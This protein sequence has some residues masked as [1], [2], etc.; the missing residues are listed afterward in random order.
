MPQYTYAQLKAAVNGR[1]HSKIGLL[2]DPRVS[3]NNGARELYSIVDLRSSKR[4]A[5]LAP[6]LFQDVYSYTWPTDGK[7]MAFID[8]QRQTT[9]RPKLERWSLVGEANFDQRKTLSEGLIAFT[10]RD[11]ARKLLVSTQID[12]RTLTVSPLDSTT[13]GGGTWT[14]VGDA[15]NIRT[16]SQNYVK[17]N[18]SLEF[19]MNAGGT[20]AGVQ[21]TALTTFDLTNYLANGSVFVWA[22]ITTTTYI[23]S[24]TLRLGSSSSNFYYQTVTATNEGTAFQQGWNLLRFD[25]N[26]S[27]TTG[28]PVIASCTYASVFMTKTGAKPAD[29]AYRFDNLMVKNGRFYNLIYYSKYPWQ[30]AAGV[31][32]QDSTLDTDYLNVDS[33]EYQMAI[34]KCVELCGFETEDANDVT[35]AANRF[36]T[37][38]DNYTSKY[39]SEAAIWTESYYDFASIDG[40]DRIGGH[41]Y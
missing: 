24:F 38:K 30:T 17:G 7:D 40:D 41:T 32:I 25:L 14:A 6:N 37:L 4:K 9:D 33:T 22:Y 35:L 16:D 13:S 28:T 27:G 2:P 36:T 18:G 5:T 15:T 29:T 10:D 34:E 20:T 21:N 11:F 8:L 3:L 1:L 39:P 19:D 23:T 31:Y 12:D 26:G